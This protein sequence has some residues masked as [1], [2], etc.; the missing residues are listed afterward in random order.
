MATRKGSK[1]SRKPRLTRDKLLAKIAKHQVDLKKHPL[2]IV[3][4]RGYYLNSMG[5]VG[6]NDRGIYDDALFI[7]TPN[8]FASFNANTDPSSYRN[9]TSRR[10]GMATLKKGIYHSYRFDNHRTSRSNYPAICQRAADVIVHRDGDS[11][12][13]KG[14]FGINI[15]RGGYS[16][17]SSAGCQTIP[18]PQWDAFYQLAKSEAKRLFGKNW[19]KVT[20]PYILL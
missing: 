8:T 6:R 11:K 19:K 3:G 16:T 2:I 5:A 4:I 1:P 20:I 17:T 18:P 9:K 13:H 14:M 15:H 12:L 7:I 10:K